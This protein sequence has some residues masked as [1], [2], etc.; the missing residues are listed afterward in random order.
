M[1]FLASFFDAMSGIKKI[2][3]FYI[4]NEL[5]SSIVPS[6]NT[7]VYMD[8]GQIYGRRSF[9]QIARN[10]G[11]KNETNP[12]NVYYIDKNYFKEL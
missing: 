5:L 4:G 10:E 2:V 3:Y 7:P 6:I 8:I 11:I 1:P 12:S 9:R